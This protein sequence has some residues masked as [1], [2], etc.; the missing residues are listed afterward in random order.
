MSDMK[1]ELCKTCIH[2]NVCMRDK[3]IFGDI[4]IPGNPMFVDNKELFKKFEEWKADGFPCDE[5]LS[6]QKWVPCSER[7]PEESGLYL[8]TVPS[9]RISKVHSRYFNECGEGSFWSGNSLS[10]VVAWMPLP[11]PY[12]GGE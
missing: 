10:K 12:K 11:S 1:A 9:D 8:V 3:N 5:Y 4:F 2:T 7:L 6:A